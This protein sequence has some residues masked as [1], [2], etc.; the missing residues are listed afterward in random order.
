[1]HNMKQEK[2]VEFLLTNHVLYR[3]PPPSAISDLSLL[4]VCPGEGKCV[5]NWVRQKPFWDRRRK[6]LWFRAAPLHDQDGTHL[7]PGKATHLRFHSTRRHRA[8]RP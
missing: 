3:N 5:P 2:K 4:F 7:G 8:F 6:N 1:M